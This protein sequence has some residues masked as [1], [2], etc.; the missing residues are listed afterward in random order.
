MVI[1]IWWGCGFLSKKNTLSLKCPNC[2]IQSFALD[3]GIPKKY[4]IATAP[5]TV[6][7]QPCPVNHVY[8]FIDSEQGSGPKGS[9]FCWIQGILV[10]LSVYPSIHPSVLPIFRA[11]EPGSEGLGQWFWTRCSG[12]EGLWLAQGLWAWSLSWTALAIGPKKKGQGQSQR[13]L[14]RE[15]WPENLGL[16]NSKTS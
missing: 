4:P 15:P 16:V 10:C 12:T 6:Y 8:D 11:R 7:G 13:A 5:R 14:A 3:V 9:M 2:F 1:H